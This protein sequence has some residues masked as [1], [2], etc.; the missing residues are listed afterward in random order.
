M[1]KMQNQQTNGKSQSRKPA[2]PGD[3][4]RDNPGKRIHNGASIPGT[5]GSASA[6]LSGNQVETPILVADDNRINQLVASK[7]LQRFGFE[8][9]VANDGYEAIDML[10]QHQFLMV[11]MDV[12]MP[13]IDGLQT[14]RMIRSGEAGEHSIDI[15]IVAMTGNADAQGRR[16]CLEAGMNHHIAKPIIQKTLAAVMHQ[17]GIHDKIFTRQP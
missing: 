13:G 5:A 17:L 15:P 12:Q 6:Q 2:C 14:T 10:Q 4:D 1:N 7:M 3:S 8:V 16:D 11:F 9:V